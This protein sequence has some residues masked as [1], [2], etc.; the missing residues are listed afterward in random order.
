MRWCTADRSLQRRIVEALQ[1]VRSQSNVSCVLC[2][3]KTS[4]MGCC[5]PC[6]D[7]TQP[8]VHIVTMVRIASSNFH[9][10]LC[11][12]SLARRGRA[13]EG[14]AVRTKR[15]TRWRSKQSKHDAKRSPAHLIFDQGADVSARHGMRSC[16]HAV[17]GLR[18][19]GSTPAAINFA[20]RH[21]LDVSHEHVLRS[22]RPE[23][24]G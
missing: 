18:K 23:D 11:V 14:A 21:H 9:R 5:Q 1:W 20:R 7:V 3:T 24:F 2:A 17:A 10:K 8:S 6:C 12:P 16:A 4:R 15:R 22:R 13:R 19:L